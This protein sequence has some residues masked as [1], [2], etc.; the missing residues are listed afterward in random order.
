MTKKLSPI[1]K[2]KTADLILGREELLKLIE[3]DAPNA[4]AQ[5]VKVEAIKLLARMHKALQVDKVV[6]T[7]TANA[8]QAQQQLAPAEMEL[9]DAEIEEILGRDT[10]TKD[11]TLMP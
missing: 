11:K 6:A 3:A 1:E 2:H 5:K 9:I 10:T 7:A 4:T 8:Q